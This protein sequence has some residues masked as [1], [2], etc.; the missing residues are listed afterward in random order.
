MTEERT[1]IDELLAKMGPTYKSLNITFWVCATALLFICLTAQV[2]TPVSGWIVTPVAICMFV[3]WGLIRSLAR[4]R[5]KLEAL[6]AQ[7]RTHV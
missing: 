2:G 5:A 3:H 4:T 1:S 6:K 7:G